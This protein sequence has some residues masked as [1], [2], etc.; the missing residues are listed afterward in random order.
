MRKA[1]LDDLSSIMKV[2]RDTVEEMR[3]YNNTQWDENYP[4]ESDFA[5]DIEKEELYVADRSGVLAGF[6]CINRVE[7]NEYKTVPWSRECPSLVIHR[8]AVDLQYRGQGV[9]SE[10]V[11]YAEQ[12]AKNLHI[13]YLKTDTYSLNTNAQKLFESCGYRWI[14]TMTFLG[15]E[16][17]FKCCE[18]S[19]R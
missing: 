2:M 6:I 7:P 12:L 3:S 9:G 16:K 1:S 19:L 5:A 4:Q 15:K 10:L 11:N 13:D 17:P 18:K 8:M 14:G